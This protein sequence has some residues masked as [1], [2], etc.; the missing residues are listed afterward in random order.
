LVLR[1][2]DL[3]PRALCDQLAAW[4]AAFDSE[5][6]EALKALP[7]LLGQPP[8]RAVDSICRVGLQPDHT[9][10]WTG[11][12]PFVTGSVLWSLFS[13]LRSPDDYWEAICTAIAVGGD[14]DT[15]AA[16]TGAIAG[17]HLG[18][19]GVPEAAARLVTDQGTWEYEDLNR[20]A[21]ELY[22]LHNGLRGRATS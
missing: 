20:L 12:S 21:H 9:D 18:L 19:K 2:G 1:D 16:M 17:A 4:T 5:L 7:T 8:A 15:T 22:H 14:V 11:I 10:F 13:F 3:D 6:S